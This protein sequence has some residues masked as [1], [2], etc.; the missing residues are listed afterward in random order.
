[1]YRIPLV[2]SLL[3]SILACGD[4]TGPD[5]DDLCMTVPLPLSDDPNGPTVVDVGLELQPGEGVI[6]VAT[7]TDPQGTANLRDVQQTVGVFPDQKC[8]G[9]PLTL[10]D[11]LVGSGIEETFGTAVSFSDNLALYRAIEAASTWPV[12]L[13]FGDADGHR[14]E[15]RALARIIR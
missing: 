14:T 11:D 10:H 12:D 4:G 7:A 1:M 3:F 8:K 9:T 2:F 5:K 6:I 15:G 13:S